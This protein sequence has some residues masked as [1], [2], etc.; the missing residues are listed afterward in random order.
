MIS[1]SINQSI[2]QAQEGHQKHQNREATKAK[3]KQL[4]NLRQSKSQTII[5]TNHNKAMT[6]I[7]QEKKETDKTA[8]HV[9]ETPLSSLSSVLF[10][11]SSFD[12]T[13]SWSVFL[14]SVHFL[15]LSLL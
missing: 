1:Q 11:L 9:S 15:S 3:V 2:N 6:E 4:S 10:S 5:N 7:T 13:S 14:F 12:L 8:I